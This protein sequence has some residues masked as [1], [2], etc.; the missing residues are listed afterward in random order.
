[1]MIEGMFTIILVFCLLLFIFN[2][3]FL[4]VKRNIGI[5]IIV[6]EG[7][8]SSGKSFI[9]KKMSGGVEKRF[10]PIVGGYYVNRTLDCMFVEEPLHL[11][12]RNNMLKTSL[13]S[14]SSQHLFQVTASHI[15]HTHLDHV[16][17]LGVK[18]N[19]GKI[20]IERHLIT[21][22]HTFGQIIKEKYPVSVMHLTSAFELATEDLVLKYKSQLHNSVIL[23]GCIYVKH[24]S[25]QALV[26][27]IKTRGRQYEVIALGDKKIYPCNVELEIEQRH[28][29]EILNVP[30][31]YVQKKDESIKLMLTFIR[32][33]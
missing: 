4:C 17:A 12:M 24:F 32:Q 2:H 1:M 13:Q 22:Y 10:H 6:C 8:V 21:V 7:L 26:E 18:Y 29:L 25:H 27:N 14:T 16:I 9:I 30:I 19:I 28:M 5:K 20:V 11:L 3:F 23:H 33:L 31:Y 15:L